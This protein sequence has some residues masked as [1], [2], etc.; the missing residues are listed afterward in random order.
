MAD[1]LNFT[2][3]SQRKM[4][5]KTFGTD[6][7]NDMLLNEY[8]F[9]L[10]GIKKKTSVNLKGFPAPLICSP[11]SGQRIGIVKEE[12][13]F[14]Q[15]FDLADK[16]KG[17][18]DIDVLIGADYYWDIVEGEIK[19]EN[20]ERLIAL[21]SKLGLLLSGPLTT[22]RPVTVSVNFCYDSCIKS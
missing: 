22:T 8:N 12:C 13:S 11:L 20:N 15:G 19:R 7:A 16:G 18:S 2:P 3:I 1:R 21:K 10:M 4:S 14:L 9:S 5:V 17:D 6:K